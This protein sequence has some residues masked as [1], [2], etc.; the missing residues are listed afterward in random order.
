MI[1]P[2][3]TSRGNGTKLLFFL[4]EYAKKELKAKRIIIHVRKDNL[5]AIKLYTK[6]GFTIKD[7]DLIYKLELKI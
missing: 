7:N 1:D 4:I 2:L 6:F 3:S 5:I